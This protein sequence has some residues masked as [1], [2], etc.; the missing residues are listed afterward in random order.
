MILVHTES[1]DMI[2]GEGRVYHNTFGIPALDAEM[3]L[4]KSH[5]RACCS[6]AG[7]NVCII[8]T[9][10]TKTAWET[11]PDSRRRKLKAASLL[12]VV[13]LSVY[14][15]EIVEARWKLSLYRQQVLSVRPWWLHLLCERSLNYFEIF[16][17]EWC[18]NHSFSNFII[19][20]MW[21]KVI[22]IL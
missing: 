10:K 5:G 4:T 12:V 16:G 6:T 13:A 15:P 9:V 8:R 3:C 11:V 22:R 21:L 1:S 20:R 19:L 7:Q 14:I 18:P 17:C 2:H